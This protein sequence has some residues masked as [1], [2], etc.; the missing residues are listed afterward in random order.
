[1]MMTIHSEVLL[2]HISQD[3]TNRVCFCIVRPNV[4]GLYTFTLINLLQSDFI[5]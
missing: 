5:G 3:F 1:M 4:H 2:L